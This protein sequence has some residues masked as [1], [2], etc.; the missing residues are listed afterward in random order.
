M[1]GGNFVVVRFQPRSTNN[2]GMSASFLYVLVRSEP[3]GAD[4]PGERP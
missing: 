4:G 1:S 3:F 2:A